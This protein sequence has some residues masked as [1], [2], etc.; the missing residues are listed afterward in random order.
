VP[1]VHIRDMY[2]VFDDIA[3]AAE[4]AIPDYNTWTLAVDT[5]MLCVSCY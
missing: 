4:T 5:V 1:T 3:L 2:R